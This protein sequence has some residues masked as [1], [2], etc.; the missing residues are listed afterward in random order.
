[1]LSA[2]SHEFVQ[3]QLDCE[4]QVDLLVYDEIVCKRIGMIAQCHGDRGDACF[5]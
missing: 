2:A 1:M 5:D 4:E 3:T